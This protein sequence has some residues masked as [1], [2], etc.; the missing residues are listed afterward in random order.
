MTRSNNDNTSPTPSS[1]KK[2]TSA[3]PYGPRRRWGNAYD[4]N[5]LST[6]NLTSPP[7]AS[8]KKGSSMKKK[9]GSNVAPWRMQRSSAR[10]GLRNNLTAVSSSLM[11]SNKKRAREREEE[12]TDENDDQDDFFSSPGIP[13]GI[14]ARVNGL[15]QFLEALKIG[16]VV[17]R[18]WPNGK[19]VFIQLFSDDG[20]DTIEFKYVPD[21]EAVIALK[22]QAQ[23]Y[24]GRRRKKKARLSLGERESRR[25][26]RDS[27]TTIQT[28]KHHAVVPLPDYLKARLTERKIS[29]K[30][31]G[32]ET[33]FLT[34]R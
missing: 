4:N 9:Q 34:A 28:D 23:R 15:D 31:R 25:T 32:S 19:S 17:R 5:K 33:L 30:T 22:E 10:R 1:D 18:H 8:L 21:D 7:I 27:Q 6:P 29:E 11:N 16:I 12:M 14:A 2:L 13:R 3:S 24:N 26:S 20:G